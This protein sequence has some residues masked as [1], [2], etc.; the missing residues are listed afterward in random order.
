M[1]RR[2][3]PPFVHEATAVLGEHGYSADVD[4]GG[5]GHFKITWIAHDGRQRLFVVARTSSERRADANARATLRR[6]LRE[7]GRP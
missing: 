3:Y 4:L 1:S 2:R 7:E 6:L 5:A